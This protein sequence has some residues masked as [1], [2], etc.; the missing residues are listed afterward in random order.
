ML[1]KG[2]KSKLALGEKAVVTSSYNKQL[3]ALTAFAGTQTHGLPSLVIIAHVFCA[4]KLGVM[5]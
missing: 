3:L 1:C 2:R 4:L 5:F